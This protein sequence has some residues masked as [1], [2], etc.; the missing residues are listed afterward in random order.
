MEC[1]W[2]GPGRGIPRPSPSLE[3]ARAG[4][5]QV[6]AILPRACPFGQ[7]GRAK[8]GFSIIFLFLFFDLFL[9]KFLL[10]GKTYSGLAGLDFELFTTSP[11]PSYGPTQPMN[12]PSAL[13][14]FPDYEIFSYKVH[15]V[16]LYIISSYLL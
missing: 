16:I 5:G 15:P 7:L 3:Q 9:G 10:K 12:T 13:L 14:A 8:P 1:L 4:L 11:K 2:V 6:E